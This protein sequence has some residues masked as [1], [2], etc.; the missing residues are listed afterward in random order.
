MTAVPVFQALEMAIRFHSA[1]QLQQA[2]QIYRQILALQPDNP[3]A[4]HLLGVIAH[5][6]GKSVGGLKLIERAIA[7]NPGC[8]PYYNNYGEVLR[9]LKRLQEAEAAYRKSLEL[10]PNSPDALSNLAI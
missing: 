8:S 4:L 5:Q 2:E 6:V 7:L 9:A 3:D 1:G 10:N